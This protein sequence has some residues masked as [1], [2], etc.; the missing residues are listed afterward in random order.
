MYGFA[1][2]LGHCI[3]RWRWTGLLSSSPFI[4]PAAVSF[5]TRCQALI[6]PLPNSYLWKVTVCRWGDESLEGDTVSSLERVKVRNDSTGSLRLFFHRLFSQC[7][8][9]DAQCYGQCLVKGH[10]HKFRCYYQNDLYGWA[11]TKYWPNSALSHKLSFNGI[12]WN[13]IYSII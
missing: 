1:R 12:V 5:L 13:I 10:P 8:V 3:W 6:F 7:R 11:L 2:A 4:Q 9:E